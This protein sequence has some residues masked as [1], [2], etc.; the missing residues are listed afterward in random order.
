[1]RCYQMLQYILYRDHA[2]NNS[3]ANVPYEIKCTGWFTFQMTRHFWP[4]LDNGL[5]K[6]FLKIFI[7]TVLLVDNDD[8][9]KF[10]FGR[11]LSISRKW[12]VIRRTAD[13]CV[14]R[15]R[16]PEFRNVENVKS[17]IMNRQG[18][19]LPAQPG[20]LKP[21]LGWTRLVQSHLRRPKLTSVSESWICKVA[22]LYRIGLPSTTAT[23]LALFGGS[24]RT[25]LHSS[26]ICTNRAIMPNSRCI[27][28]IMFSS[29]QS[30]SGLV[31]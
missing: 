30:Y 5:I 29:E 10:F 9:S 21:G 26:S 13:I 16:K 31:S 27:R 8:N 12:D 1:M 4:S 20:Q 22:L 15:K 25:E 18:W 19:T 14:C 23:P 6:G 7:A 2:V 28:S 11:K 17:K 3:R 24:L